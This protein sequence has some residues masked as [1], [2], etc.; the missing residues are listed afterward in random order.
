M[1]E[2]GTNSLLALLF[3]ALAGVLAVPFAGNREVGKAHETAATPSAVATPAPTATPPGSGQE[4]AAPLLTWFPPP[5][6]ES[7]APDTEG[8][9]RA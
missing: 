1:K 5:A 6:E 9:S 7:R 4:I 2:G 3:L 8:S